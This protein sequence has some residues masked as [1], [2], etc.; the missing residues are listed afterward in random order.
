MPKRWKAEDEAFLLENSKKMSRAELAEHFGVT[1]KSIS[2]KLR[3]LNRK[4]GGKKAE[5]IEKQ[6]TE[7]PLNKYGERKKAFIRGFIRIIDYRDLAKLAGIK[8]DDLK[9]TVEKT[10]IKLPYER[11]RAWNEIDVGKYRSLAMCAR[12]QVQCNHSSFLVG[13][14][15]CRKCYEKNIRHWLESEISVDISFRGTD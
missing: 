9:D 7:D 3:R 4:A 8:P 15:N 13:I 14:N 2:D 6:G 12:C 10:G 5:Q 1:V 11:A